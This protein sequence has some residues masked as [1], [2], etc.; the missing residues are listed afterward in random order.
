[1]QVAFSY[2]DLSKNIIKKIELKAEPLSLESKQKKVNARSNS[3]EFLVPTKTNS[4]LMTRNEVMMII[5]EKLMLL[6]LMAM[7]YNAMTTMVRLSS[8]STTS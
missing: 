5:F 4:R 3:F 7:V 2:K 8:F 6:L 1:M